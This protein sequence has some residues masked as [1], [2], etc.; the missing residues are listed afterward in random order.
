MTALCCTTAS[1]EIVQLSLSSRRPSIERYRS[2]CS[3][4]VD[5]GVVFVGRAKYSVEK[6][7]GVESESGLRLL[8]SV[9]VPAS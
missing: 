2:C 5:C 1:G 8:V 6:T 4:V 3:R 9:V 7:R